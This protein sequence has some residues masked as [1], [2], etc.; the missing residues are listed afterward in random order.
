MYFLK[1]C[2]RCGGD[3]T[4]DSDQYGDYVSCLQC[5]LCR[6]IPVMASGSPIVRTDPAHSSRIAAWGD[7]RCRINP[8]QPQV[9]RSTESIP[10]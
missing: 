6:D 3:L 7:A 4:T 1:Q 9:G 5:G 2:P 8:L 10:A